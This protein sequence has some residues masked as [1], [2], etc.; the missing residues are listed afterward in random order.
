MELTREGSDKVRDSRGCGCWGGGGEREEWGGGKRD[1]G[2][3][4][5][6]RGEGRRTWRARVKGNS[7]TRRKGEREE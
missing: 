5:R 3:S 4:K 6:N 7:G 2:T 1:G